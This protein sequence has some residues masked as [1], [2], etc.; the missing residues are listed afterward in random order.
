MPEGACPRAGQ[1]VGCNVTFLDDPE[2]GEELATEEA[3]T[4]AE[5][6]QRRQRSQQWPAA[7]VASVIAFHSP[8]RN[9]GRGIHTIFGLDP[10]QHRRPF[11]QHGAA[12]CHALVVDQRS[13][14]IPDR[15]DE[16]GLGVEKANDRHVGREGR[17]VGVVGRAAHALGLRI[18][19]QAGEAGG[20]GRFVGVRRTK[21]G[22]ND[23]RG[24]QDQMAWLHGNSGRTIRA[25]V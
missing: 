11:G 20:E 7:E 21:E 19:A 1:A 8:H 23:E 14:V 24:A 9:H 22:R 17:S 25:G 3:L 12:V 15:R 5:A 13:E 16:F 10:R 4:P 18:G 2:R 6:R